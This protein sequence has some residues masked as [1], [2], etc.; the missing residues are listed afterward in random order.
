MDNYQG[1]M[2]PKYLESP[3]NP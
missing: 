3:D 2:Q 1:H